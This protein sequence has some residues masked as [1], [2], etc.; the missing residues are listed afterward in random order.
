MN[1]DPLNESFSLNSQTSSEV[2]SNYPLNAYNYPYLQ[3]TLNNTFKVDSELGLPVVY[4]YNP[5]NIDFR[6][7]LASFDSFTS[8]VSPE[9]H[10][11]LA[12]KPLLT[13]PSYQIDF[14]NMPVCL[15]AP[16]TM[17][18]QSYE[19][20]SHTPVHSSKQHILHSPVYTD[21]LPFNSLPQQPVS[22][23]EPD[24]THQQLQFQ[25]PLSTYHQSAPFNITSSFPSFKAKESTNLQC[26]QLINASTYPDEK[27]NFRPQQL[28][29]VPLLIQDETI[30]DTS[31]NSDYESPLEAQRESTFYSDINSNSSLKAKNPSTPLSEIPVKS[32]LQQPSSQVSFIFPY[33]TPSLL[34]SPPSS[35]AEFGAHLPVIIQKQT[36]PH[37]SQDIT[38]NMPVENKSVSLSNLSESLNI[39]QSNNYTHPNPHS[40]PT[41]PGPI[42]ITVDPPSMVRN[43]KKSKYTAHQ[44]QLILKLKKQL[45]SWDEIARL[46]SLSNGLAARN[47]YQVLV[48]QQGL[49]NIEE[50][51]EMEWTSTEVS[52]LR[53]VL[54]SQ[55]SSVDIIR[56]KDGGAVLNI[57][58]WR[59]VA[60][61]LSH[62]RQKK[63]TSKKCKKKAKSMLMNEPGWLEKKT[64]KR[65]DKETSPEIAYYLSTS[66]SVSSLESVK[67]YP[68]V[69]QVIPR[70]PES[71]EQHDDNSKT[72]NSRVDEYFDRYF[73]GT[74]HAQ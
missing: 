1:Q 14:S 11:S 28:P 27:N 21:H 36:H 71:I 68:V 48:G 62:I 29:L 64:P 43:K 10:A 70:Q 60:Q 16:L 41:R 65:F 38:I 40:P 59:L 57:I 45:K 69:A 30:N 7:I 3:G 66:S 73:F 26:S 46:T 15:S 4:P 63:F 61:E 72:K 39:N 47:R 18:S 58:Q 8:Y 24:S 67:E 52:S 5:H 44:D 22:K 53:K 33:Q 13:H 49:H 17:A 12:P 32:Q 35:Q 25:I 6:P 56:E 54:K 9:V 50:G 19:P 42:A 31:F 55:L 51:A 23:M 34:S 37:I 20:T 74:Y 2:I